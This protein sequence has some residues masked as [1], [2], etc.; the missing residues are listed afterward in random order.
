MPVAAKSYYNGERPAG[1]TDFRLVIIALTMWAVAA[2]EISY[3]PPLEVSAGVALICVL[4]A[5]FLVRSKTSTH[6]SR[7]KR[8]WLPDSSVRSTMAL[9]LIAISCVA[10]RAGIEVQAFRAHPLVAMQ[11]QKHSSND[12]GEHRTTKTRART[13][14]TCTLSVDSL[15]VPDHYGGFRAQGSLHHCQLPKTAEHPRT[16]M[17]PTLIHPHIGIVLT[18]TAVATF[19]RGEILTVR[20]RITE[21]TPKRPG[22]AGKLRVVHVLDHHSAGPDVH[23]PAAMRAYTAH[24]LDERSRETQSL[25]RGMGLG[26]KSTFT[27]DD[28]RAFQRASLAHLVAVSGLHTGIILGALTAFIPGR[29]T[30]K[31]SASV[32]LL[33]LILIVMGPSASVIR[34]CTMTALGLL[35]VWRGKGGQ[36]SPGLAV[37]IIGM[38][39]WNPWNAISMSFALSVAA[40]AGVIWPAQWAGRLM[41]RWVK[42][43]R[44]PQRLHQII[45]GFGEALAVSMSAQIF[46]LPI[47]GAYGLSVSREAVIANV[48]VAPIVAPVCLGAL[49][50]VVVSAFSSSAAD[51]LAWMLEPLC[52]WIFLV[53]RFFGAS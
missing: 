28:M 35:A 25:L 17:L 5:I 16:P 29:G 50:V 3:H 14:I 52:Q 6:P 11:E 22:I 43:S 46:T 7:G 2:L 37:A 51:A 23:I 48:A 33:A 32:L 12:N 42:R 1:F 30:T 9:L 53:A 49:A 39:I 26:D 4:A 15:P 47:V 31:T 40:T 44:L 13:T 34:A 18:G 10:L 36:S 24:A 8:H 45:I 20:G 41:K 21:I 27:Q 38:I 19:Q